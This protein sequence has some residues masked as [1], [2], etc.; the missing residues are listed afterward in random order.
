[1][2][3]MNWGEAGRKLR[4]EKENIV[5]D[6]INDVIKD[7]KVKKNDENEIKLIEEHIIIIII[8]KI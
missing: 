2:V 1:M 8:I 5:I 3:E 7:E 4:K 6:I